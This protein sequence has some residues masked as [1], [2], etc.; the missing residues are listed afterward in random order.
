MTMIPRVKR[1]LAVGLAL[2]LS[3]R[4]GV[5]QAQGFT[6]P[7]PPSSGFSPPGAPPSGFSP[8]GAQP[9][10]PAPPPPAQPAYVP[11]PAPAPPATTEAAPVASP[12]AA[13]PPPAPTD[14]IKGMVP[15]ETA[16]DGG[17]T[18][19]GHTFILPTF[20][21]NAFTT[22][23]FSV[24]TGLGLYSQPNNIGVDSSTGKTFT[25]DV[26][27]GFIDERFAFGWAP[28]EQ[29]QLHLDSSYI[30]IVGG[31]EQGILLFGGKTSYAF[32]PG[33]K[34]R[35]YHGKESG[36]QI[37]LHGY[38]KIAG[39]IQLRPAGLL[40]A[41]AAQV[42]A[43][44]NDPTAQANAAACLASGDFGC[45]LPSVSDP[46]GSMTRTDSTYGGGGALS[47]AQA[48]GKYAGAQLSAGATAGAATLK[49]KALDKS[50]IT[51]ADV[52]LS[53]VPWDFHLGLAGTLN[54]APT[55]PVGLKAEYQF[56]R[57][58]ESFQVNGADSGLSRVQVDHAVA[59]GLYYT[60]RR[61]LQLGWFLAGVFTKS[62]LSD[63]GTPADEPGHAILTGQFEM[64]YFF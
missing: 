16:D 37:A 57:T 25:Y 12:P 60:G 55:V 62:T 9:A 54:F 17:R 10:L 4:A 33:L 14:E 23:L 22:T 56:T 51:L 43:L 5:A 36:T 45:A 20:V 38:A 49:L 15:G 50:S 26:N 39:G 52:T 59:A 18:L 41:M 47:V 58:S 11:P 40:E 1:R 21:D 13:P 27:M 35:L 48:L 3:A 30:A 53:S 46:L 24:G 44:K 34:V 42:A 6:P 64:R 31:N 28:V 32:Q 2:F 29:V 19:N 7:G 61:D 63:S 8:P